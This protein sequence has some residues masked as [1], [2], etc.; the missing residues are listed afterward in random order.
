MRIVARLDRRGVS[1]QH[2]QM[3]RY[4]RLV[5][6][7]KEGL[8]VTYRVAGGQVAEFCRAMCML[9]EDGVTEIDRIVRAFLEGRDGMGM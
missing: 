9:A 7:E 5:E 6:A 3:P 8:F 4:A 1:F 2:L